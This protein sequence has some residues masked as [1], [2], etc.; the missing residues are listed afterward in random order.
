[1]YIPRPDQRI[2]VVDNCQCVCVCGG[3]WSP[4]LTTVLEISTAEMVCF[5]EIR[6]TV[7]PLVCANPLY[8][9]WEFGDRFGDNIRASRPQWSF[10]ASLYLA[11]PT[12]A[13]PLH[14]LGHSTVRRHRTALTQPA[15]ATCPPPT[16][17]E[18]RPQHG[19]RLWEPPEIGVHGKRPSYH[20]AT[21]HTH[22]YIGLVT[23]RNVGCLIINTDYCELLIITNINNALRKDFQSLF[24][25]FIVG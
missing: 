23:P 22:T 21:P 4:Q 3:Q 10:Y 1:M 14:C 25:Y 15:P 13:L 7:G 19:T 9:V 5:G 12:L 18:G 6:G 2:P 17:C 8:V 20:H 16:A 24:G 11:P